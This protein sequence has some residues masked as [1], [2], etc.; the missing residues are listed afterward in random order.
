[1][2]LYQ[3]GQMYY[4]SIK[5]ETTKE[6]VFE[7]GEG[8]NITSIIIRF[9]N[10]AIMFGIGMLIARNAWIRPSF[11][12]IRIPWDSLIMIE[13]SI[14]ILI[15]AIDNI[16]KDRIVFWISRMSISTGGLRHYFGI[17]T[18]G[19]S[20]WG[21]CLGILKLAIFLRFGSYLLE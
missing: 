15:L 6:F 4:S 21:I 10:A 19:F 8:K 20:V 2:L 17:L 12:L 13:I 7:R 16:H 11:L 3:S 9:M 18:L 1:M 5:N 14:L